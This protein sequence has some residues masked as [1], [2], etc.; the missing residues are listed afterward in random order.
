MG[1][2]VFPPQ[3]E[4]FGGLACG[5]IGGAAVA[6]EHRDFAEQVA[7]AHEIQ[8]QPAAV[9]GA[10]FNADLPAPHPEQGVAGVALL[11]QHLA[12]AQILGVA[13]ARDSLQLVGA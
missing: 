12:H 4:Q 3:H 7:R 2:K 11:E 9:G 10:G 8:R 1:K 5:R 6:V 13:K